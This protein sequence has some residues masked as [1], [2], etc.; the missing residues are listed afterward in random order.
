MSGHNNDHL[1]I[2][3]STDPP[4]LR[5]KRCGWSE[6]RPLPA[7]VDE[8]AARAAELIREHARCGTIPLPPEPPPDRIIR[9]GAAPTPPRI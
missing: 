6:P 9:E 2:D 4:M 7:S 5:C 8:L 3:G 1:V